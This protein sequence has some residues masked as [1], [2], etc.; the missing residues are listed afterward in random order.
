MTVGA[1]VTPEDV[2]AFYAQTWDLSYTHAL[3]LTTGRF[4]KGLG[5]RRILGRQCP[6]CERVLVPP[7]AFCDRCHVD[8]GDWVDVGPLG[9]IEMF[10]VIYEP[11]KG[12]PAPPYALAYATLDGADTALVGYVKGVDLTDVKRAVAKIAIGTRVVVR[13]ADEP[14]GTVLDYWFELADEGGNAE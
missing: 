4:L 12:L 1:H 14:V 13:F 10:T 6:S 3:G 8:T 11:F 9:T 7:R 2:P 5:D